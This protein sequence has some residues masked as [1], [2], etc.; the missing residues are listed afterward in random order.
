MQQTAKSFGDHVGLAFQ[1]DQ[2]LKAFTASGVQA[3]EEAMQL[4]AVPVVLAAESAPEAD[5]VFLRE[6]LGSSDN[7]SKEERARVLRIVDEFDGISRARALRELHV[8]RALAV[9]DT[10]KESK[11]RERLRTLLL[12]LATRG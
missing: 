8:D 7:L 10:L 5:T 6:C 11:A 2:E 12:S 3:E 4:L 1:I 9:L